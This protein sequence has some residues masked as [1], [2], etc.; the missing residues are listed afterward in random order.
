MTSQQAPALYFAWFA[1]ESAWFLPNAET[2]TFDIEKAGRFTLE[3]INTLKK[4]HAYGKDGSTVSSVAVSDVFNDD[5]TPRL[6]R[7]FEVRY[8][9]Y[10]L[11][12]YGSRD[13]HL[14]LNCRELL[15]PVMEQFAN[16]PSI[17]FQLP[18]AKGRRKPQEYGRVRTWAWRLFQ[19]MNWQVA[20]S[21]EAA[22]KAARDY[23]RRYMQS[24]RDCSMLLAMR[25][26][27]KVVNGIES[28][29]Q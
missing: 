25:H 14:D 16:G 20:D 4:Q 29:L 15:S 21:A 22:E 7:D 11:W 13:E 24:T 26:N 17:P 28:L 27:R 23:A 2:C 12:G 1:W 6:N 5:G 19:D 3:E 9:D 10:V 8:D 18:D